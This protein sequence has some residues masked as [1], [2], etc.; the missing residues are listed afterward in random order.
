MSVRGGIGTVPMSARDGKSAVHYRL[1]F[2]PVWPSGF[3]TMG[4]WIQVPEVPPYSHIN[5]TG[6]YQ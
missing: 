3:V 5:L 2:A 6:I 4:D 1:L